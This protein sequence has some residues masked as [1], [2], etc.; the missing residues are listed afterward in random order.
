MS[1]AIR[2][3]RELQST[4]LKIQ[5]YLHREGVDVLDQHVAAENVLE[6]E[7]SFSEEEIYLQD[8]I[9]LKECDG[10]VAEVSIPSL[11]VGYEISYALNTLQKPVLALYREDR[12]PISVM[13]L[14]N[15]SPLLT[16]CCYRNE[17]ELFTF[18]HRFLGTL[19]KPAH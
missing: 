4:Y 17:R 3:G 8:I 7:M 14:G 6:I 15:V 13:I 12:E 16:I 5:N 1:G 19:S 10:V 2:G 11:G 9:W 18:I